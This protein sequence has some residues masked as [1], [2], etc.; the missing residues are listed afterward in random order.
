MLPIATASAAI[1]R[2]DDVREN[3]TRNLTKP[4]R[5]ADSTVSKC[6]RIFVTVERLVDKLFFFS[7][8]ILSELSVSGQ[9]ESGSYGIII[10]N[11]MDEGKE[12]KT[13]ELDLHCNDIK[14]QFHAFFDRFANEVRFVIKF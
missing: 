8:F 13:V 6:A 2:R 1:A 3:V 9:L 4:R 12:A 7:S 5:T 11:K 14:Q 10:S